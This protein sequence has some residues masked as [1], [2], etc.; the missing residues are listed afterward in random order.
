M[1]SKYSVSHS[2]RV[3]NAEKTIEVFGIALAK[4]T[5]VP[6]PFYNARLSDAELQALWTA[7]S[8]EAFPGFNAIG[9]GAE[10]RGLRLLR[11]DHTSE[12]YTTVT[13]GADAALDLVE[14]GAAAEGLKLQPA[15]AG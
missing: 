2:A 7:N 12:P 8:N 10:L 5:S 13:I 14:S 15:L 4:N 1:R 3:E 9:K 6:A 11:F